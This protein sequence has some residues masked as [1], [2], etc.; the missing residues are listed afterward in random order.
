[1]CAVR[2][3]AGCVMRRVLNTNCRAQHGEEHTGTGATHRHAPA[4]SLCQNHSA[5]N[6]IRNDQQGP[7]H[8]RALECHNQRC[9]ERARNQTHCG[10]CPVRIHQHH[11]HQHAQRQHDLHATAQLPSCPPLHQ[12]GRRCTHD[13]KC[14]Q[15]LHDARPL[16]R[17]ARDA[18]TRNQQQH[19]HSRHD[20][21]WHVLD[22]DEGGAYS[23]GVEDLNK[24]RGEEGSGW[25]VERGGR[26]ASAH[27]KQDASTHVSDT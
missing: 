24:G 17:F 20:E 22:W 7:I 15:R 10:G 12:H 9:N 21:R 18:R 19:A 4:P 8:T 3:S 14:S 2:G 1:M 25:R 11:K 26:T 27:S 23:D 5:R 13:N 16:L 6:A